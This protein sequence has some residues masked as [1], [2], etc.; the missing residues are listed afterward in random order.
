MVSPKFNHQT[1]LITDID[2][3]LKVPRAHRNNSL[4]GFDQSLEN[5]SQHEQIWCTCNGSGWRRQGVR[6]TI[7]LKETP[8]NGLL[9]NLLFRLDT[10]PEA[11]QAVLLLR[12]P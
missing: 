8:P 1:K 2:I 12:Q 3:S 10:A 5:L 11:Q 9:D 6:N 4:N 7:A